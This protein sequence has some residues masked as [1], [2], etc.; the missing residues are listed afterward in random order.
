MAPPARDIVLQISGISLDGFI[1]LE[2]T[3]FGRPWPAPRG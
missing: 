1:A 2:N 3:A